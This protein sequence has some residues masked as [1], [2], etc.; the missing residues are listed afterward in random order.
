MLPPPA[1]IST[2]STAGTSRGSP[3]HL[4]R[5]TPSTSKVEVTAGSPPSMT[6]TLA[7]VP[8]MSNVITCSTFSRAPVARQASTPAAGPDSMMLAGYSRAS[9]GVVRPPLDCMTWR[10]P[11][12][13][14]EGERGLE[15]GEEPSD[16]RLHVGVGDDGAGPLVFAAAG[17]NVRGEGDGHRPVSRRACEEIRK[18]RSHLSLVGRVGIGMQQAHG[19]ALHPIGGQL[20]GDRRHRVGI[21]RSQHLSVGADP[22]VHLVDRAPRHQGT[23]FVEPQVVGVRSASNA[24]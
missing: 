5:F 11:V 19:D 23:G 17:R 12:K 10:S 4:R 18:E 2:S 3:L 14:R 9:A 7:V 15:V 20:L 8:P 22:F 6:P 24:P 13:P 16:D 21:E 1:P